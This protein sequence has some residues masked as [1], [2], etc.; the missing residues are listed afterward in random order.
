MAYVKDE[1]TDLPTDL[2]VLPT[3]ELFQASVSQFDALELEFDL[4]AS[5]VPPEQL[6]P[7]TDL[8]FFETAEQLDLGADLWFLETAEQLLAEQP[9]TSG[10]VANSR[11]GPTKR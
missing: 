11:F 2:S 6:D 9:Q 5:Q 4:I 3:Q 8:E 10:D 7:D 1:S